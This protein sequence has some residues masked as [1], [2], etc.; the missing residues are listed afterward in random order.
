MGE[1][2]PAMEGEGVSSLGTV[3]ILV[4]DS[5]PENQLLL[6][7]VLAPLGWRV[8]AESLGQAVG[9]RVR[10]DRPNA[11]ILDVHLPD[12]DGLA[13]CRA[14]QAVGADIPV[15]FVSTADD[16][17][18]R[19]QAFEVG[20]AD[21]L[22]RPFHPQEVVARLSHHL[23]R[24]QLQRKLQEQNQRLA[25]AVRER[26][27]TEAEFRALLE[28]MT[29]VIAVYDRQGNCLRLVRT[30]SDLSFE[31]LAEQYAKAMRTQVEEYLAYI[32]IVLET[33]ET[34]HDAEYTLT[35]DGREFW[36]S[37][38]ISP[39]GPDQVLWV[40]REIT[41]RK[42]VDEALQRS[43]SFLNAQKEAA[44]DGILA[45]DEQ[46]RII[47]Y[48]HQFCQMWQLPERVLAGI[49]EERLLMALIWRAELPEE[50]A[51][52]VEAAYDN[53]DWPQRAEIPFGD[54]VFDCY[55]GPVFSPAGKFYGMNWYFR[56]VTERF[57]A[58]AAIA[59]ERD[60]ADR[61]LLN[62]LPA[63]I[64]NRLKQNETT[65]AD[66]FAEVT[67]LFSD[68][69]GFTKIA[70]Y[71]TPVELVALL[72]EIFSAFD[73]IAEAHGL[74]KIKTI[75]DEYMAVAGL[76]LPA[77]DHACRA[78]EA[79]LAMQAAIGRFQNEE[80]QPIQLRVGL[81]S[82]PVVAGVIGRRKFAYDLW[83]DAVNLASR[84]ESQGEPGKIQVTAATYQYLQEHYRLRLRGNIEVKGK[85]AMAT[86]W[87]EGH[88]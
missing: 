41:G 73:A 67:I 52:M 6:A 40:A 77:S 24:Q 59:A 4:V 69:V 12:M 32:Q 33:Q 17:T 78:A 37:A 80:G 31:L 50:L 15:L 38:N 62:I 8:V 26:A 60:K 28:A 43:S 46:G 19:L 18:L 21:F 16:T 68:I 75:G 83:G 47:N 81:H 1:L 49:E 36:F 76:S 35:L 2:R 30:N 87:L 5:Q 86:Y 14:I 7:R 45:V 55:S 88:R 39:L 72:D 79:A 11:V 85:G 13:V 9:E 10:R 42:R 56:D 25:E 70:T 71:L 61:L 63:P 3:V 53:P 58:Q 51:A 23:A 57:R 29:D 34:V 20:G 65:I 48:N 64:A 27:R 66:S 22:V 82:G 74:E 54:R 84:M 44:L